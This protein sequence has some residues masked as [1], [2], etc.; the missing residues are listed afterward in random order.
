MKTRVPVF[1]CCLACIL[2][3]TPIE[4]QTIQVDISPAHATNHF[5]PNETLG[6]GVDRIPS[7]AVDTG[8]TQPNLGRALEAGW[9]PVSYRNN[10]ELSIEAWHWNSQGTWSEPGEKG[11]FTGSTTPAE[12]IRHSYGYSLPHRG[13]TRTDGTPNAG[14][15]RITDGD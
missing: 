3:V 7:E 1:A 10:T 5:R 9:Q 2:S 12:P 11:Y 15:S 14:Y 8:L 6:A 4:A 13:F